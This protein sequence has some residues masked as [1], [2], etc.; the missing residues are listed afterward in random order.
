MAQQKSYKN[1][2]SCG[3]PLSKDPQGGGT[4]AD[5]S[6]STKYC[7]HCYQHGKFTLPDITMEQMQER[8]RGKIKE[9]GLPGFM[10]GFFVRG[11]PKLERWRTSTP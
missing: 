9:I 7:S 3:M 4:E 11:I 1:C 10:A 8:V 6:K 5:G 2:Q